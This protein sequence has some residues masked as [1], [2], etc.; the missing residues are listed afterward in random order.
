MWPRLH[1]PL[2]GSTRWR[3]WVWEEVVIKQHAAPCVCLCVCAWD[4]YFEI[5]FL[6][7]V[8]E[9]YNTNAMFT[10]FLSMHRF[11]GHLKPSQAF[12]SRLLSFVVFLMPLAQIFLDSFFRLIV[13]HRDFAYVLRG[14]LNRKARLNT[15]NSRLKRAQC[16]ITTPGIR[17][18]SQ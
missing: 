17:G 9:Q 3:S 12:S 7:T 13:N 18:L 4:M 5:K 2:L 10:H 14:N 1:N 11:T 16:W 8:A 6:C 15:L